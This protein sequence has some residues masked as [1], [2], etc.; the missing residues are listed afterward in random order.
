MQLAGVDDSD[1]VH[2]NDMCMPYSLRVEG[3]C[4]FL[5]MWQRARGGRSGQ[6]LPININTHHHQC[7]HHSTEQKSSHRGFVGIFMTCFI[8]HYRPG[9]EL[10][11]LRLVISPEFAACKRALTALSLTQRENQGNISQGRCCRA[12]V[13]ARNVR[14][15]SDSR[16][17]MITSITTRS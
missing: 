5:Q 9:Q 16:G 6:E 8:I 7:Y 12:S 17:A 2:L 13:D 1:D 3:D 14:E 10:P 4:A 15:A 11:H